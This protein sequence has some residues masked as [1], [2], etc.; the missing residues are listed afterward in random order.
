[1]DHIYRR[2]G[3]QGLRKEIKYILEYLEF[4]M[5]KLKIIIIFPLKLWLIITLIYSLYLN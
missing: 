5:N 1:M 3:P 2:Y 4:L